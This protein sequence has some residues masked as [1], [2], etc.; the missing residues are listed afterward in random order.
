MQL[1]LKTNLEKEV[2]A[3]KENE[4]I[5]TYNAKE[6]ERYQRDLAEISKDEEGYISEALAQALNINNGEPQAQHGAITRNPNQIIS[7]GDAMLGGYSRILD[8]TGFFVYGNFK[9][10]ETLSFNY[11]NLQNA[12]FDGKKISRVTYDITN[13][14]SQAGTD[15]VK[16]VVPTDPTEGFIAYRNDGNADLRTDK[17]GFRVVAKYFLEDG[18]QVTFS[19]EKPGVFTHSSLNH[20]DIGL[21]YVKDSS[22]KFMPINASTVQV[23]NEGLARSLGYN[24]ASDL[25]L[26]EEWDTTSSRY[27]YKGAIVSTVKSGNTYTVTF[28]QGGYATEC[29]IIVLVCLKYPT[30]CMYS[31]TL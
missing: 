10:G 30:S 5:E 20:N 2:A 21:E 3:R 25:N 31:N 4:A 12:R 29:W 22:G 26:P 11:Q 27:A 15:V 16:L 18:S 9:T 1:R 7:T 24:R 23:T 17:M 6:L 19:K 14:V 8:S 28:G 13:L